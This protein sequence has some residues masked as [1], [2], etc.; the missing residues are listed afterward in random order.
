MHDITFNYVQFK[1]F[2]SYGNI[3]TR[4]NFNN[5][6]STLIVGKN[7]DDTTNGI[8]SNGSGKTTCLNALVYGLYDKPLSDMKKDNLINNIN[9]K[10]LEVIIDFNIRDKNYNITRSRK[11]KNGNDAILLENGI[12]ITLAGNVNKQIENLLGIPYDL[13]IRISVFSASLPSFLELPVKGATSNNQTTFIETL[14]GIT[15]LSE[16]AAS[17]KNLIKET[18]LD[19]KFCKQEID[20]REKEQLLLINQKNNIENKLVQWETKHQND[21]DEVTRLIQAD[22]SCELDFDQLRSNRSQCDELLLS[23]NNIKNN[24]RDIQ[25]LYDS[26][27]NIINSNNKLI[28]K[29]T[30]EISILNT[31]ICPYCKQ[32][33]KNT[34]DKISDLTNEIELATNKISEL[35]IESSSFLT[36]LSELNL[37]L[38]PISNLLFSLKDTPSFNQINLWERTPIELKNKLDNISVQQ[39]PFLDMYDELV[40]IEIPKI[41]YSKI[42]ELTKISEHQNFLLKLL[43]KKDSFLRKAILNKNLPFL[44]KQLSKYL[45]LMGLKFKVNFESDLSASI[46]LNGNK[47][48]FGNLSAG[49]RARVNIALSVAFRDLLQQIHT[50]FNIWFLDEILDVGLDTLGVQMAAKLVKLKAQDDS[51]STYIISHRDEVLGIFD[52]TIEIHLKQNFSYL[53]QD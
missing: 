31:N 13:F 3:P 35:E 38:D 52:N 44:N 39:N 8:T 17:L 29:N 19:I 48:D 40:E 21:L 7:L 18:D 43:T 34:I 25:K 53:I 49:Q 12:D 14:F 32:E 30:K 45:I 23:S 9:Q 27:N 20:H 4:L 33:Y 36:K 41:D 5:S 2:L 37:E 47:F 1:N 51:L 24:I 42:N 50:S 15:E 46:S 26:N 11:G 10:D 16:K 28:Q 22:N 6:G